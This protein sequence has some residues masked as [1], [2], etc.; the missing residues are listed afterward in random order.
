MCMSDSKIYTPWMISKFINKWNGCMF[1]FKVQIKKKKK[2]IYAAVCHVEYPV[3]PHRFQL[4]GSQL[5][6]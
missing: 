6:R 1:L 2:G 4:R 3:G 5:G